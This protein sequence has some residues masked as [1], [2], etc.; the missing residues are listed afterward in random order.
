MIVQ[1]GGES[2]LICLK[3]R[4]EWWGNDLKTFET[5]S[6]KRLELSQKTVNVAGNC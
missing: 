2:Y 4:T 1:Y 6:Q 5:V 3:G